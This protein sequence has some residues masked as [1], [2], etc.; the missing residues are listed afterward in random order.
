MIGD[1]ETT[2]SVRR[3][4]DGKEGS[5]ALF[6]SDLTMKNQGSLPMLSAVIGNEKAGAEFFRQLQPG[7][8][9]SV[10]LTSAEGSVKLSSELGLVASH[11]IAYWI[12]SDEMK[13]ALELSADY[14]GNFSVSFI[15]PL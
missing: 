13:Y 3:I 8:R 15:I 11:S 10:K 14:K 5:V 1:T 12:G 9:V 7:E 6:S 4:R 2:L